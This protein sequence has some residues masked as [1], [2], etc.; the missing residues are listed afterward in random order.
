MHSWI[1]IH[2]ENHFYLL[3]TFWLP[4]GIAEF[5]LK[6]PLIECCLLL[7]TTDNCYIRMKVEKCDW[8]WSVLC[9]IPRNTI[10]TLQK[11]NLMAH[12]LVFTHR[13]EIAFWK[14]WHLLFFP[15]NCHTHTTLEISIPTTSTKDIS[16]SRNARNFV[17]KRN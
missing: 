5:I 17:K 3:L 16:A 1:K 9:Q 12:P 11:M 7:S 13:L 14:A 4:F 2:S 10:K 6:N 8:R 15:I